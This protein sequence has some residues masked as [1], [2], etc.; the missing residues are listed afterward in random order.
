M[1]SASLTS[2]LP[3]FELKKVYYLVQPYLNHF[4]NI[5][6][7]RLAG[8]GVPASVSVASRG[9]HGLIEYYTNISKSEQG[10]E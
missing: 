7:V 10:K 3:P 5:M 6:L 4:I 8:G 9:Y 2:F 1:N